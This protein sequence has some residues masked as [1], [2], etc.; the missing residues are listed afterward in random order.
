MSTVKYN[1]TVICFYG[2]MMIQVPLRL[3]IVERSDCQIMQNFSLRHKLHR[4]LE[5][6]HGWFE[7]RICQEMECSMLLSLRD[8]M[9]LLGSVG[10]LFLLRTPSHEKLQSAL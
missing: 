10:F 6:L 2:N 4:L 7:E 5:L 1:I 9:Y 8:Q 3:F